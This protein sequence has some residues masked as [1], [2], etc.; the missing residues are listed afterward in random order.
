MC[1][2]VLCY[3][4]SDEC[5]PSLSCVIYA[6]GFDQK[7]KDLDAQNQENPAESSHSLSNDVKFLRIHEDYQVIRI[8]SQSFLHEMPK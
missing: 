2:D 5:M 3:I 1:L 7:G 8:E 6:C 4:P